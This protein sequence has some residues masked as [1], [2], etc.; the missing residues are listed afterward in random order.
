M[1]ASGR[2]K[3]GV[4]WQKNLWKNGSEICRRSKGEDKRLKKIEGR[5]GGASKQREKKNY[6]LITMSIKQHA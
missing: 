5:G 2:M 6:R 4:K 3:S 1:Q